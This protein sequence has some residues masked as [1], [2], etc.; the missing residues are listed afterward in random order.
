MLVKPKLVIALGALAAR[1]LM[2]RTVVLTRE[3]GRLLRWADG[4][5]G[6]ATIHPSAVLR[7]PDETS[8]QRALSSSSEISNRLVL[9]LTIWRMSD[10]SDLSLALQSWGRCGVPG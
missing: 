8:R 9:S 3:R 2:G 4:R 10:D 5:A 1:A 6:L 7:A